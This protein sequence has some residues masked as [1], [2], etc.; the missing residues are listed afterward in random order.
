M[1]IQAIFTLD[2]EQVDVKTLATTLSEIAEADGFVKVDVREIVPQK[3]K[4]LL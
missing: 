4:S 1:R 3:T 2:P